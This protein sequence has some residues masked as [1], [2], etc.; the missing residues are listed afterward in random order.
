MYFRRLRNC[1]NNYLLMVWG[2]LGKP[3]F[4]SGLG[5]FRVA[6]GRQKSSRNGVF[7]TSVVVFLLQ[8]ESALSCHMSCCPVPFPLCSLH[9][10]QP[11]HGLGRESH[12]DP[13]S[14]NG[15]PR[16]SFHAQASS[17]TEVSLWAKWQ[18]ECPQVMSFES[19]RRCY[20]ALLA[21]EQHGARSSLN[22]NFKELK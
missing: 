5:R 15:T 21:A 1:C 8:W 6:V 20:I 3:V 14:G 2:A 16:R 19:A 13:F 7:L 18:G 9:P 12:W 22:I 4:F 10:L 11:D 17:A